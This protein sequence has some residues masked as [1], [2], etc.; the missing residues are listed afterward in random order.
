MDFVTITDFPDYEISET[1]IVRKIENKEII[2]LSTGNKYIKVAL[3]RGKN[4]FWMYLHRLLAIQFIQ[5]PENYEY[6]NHKNG[7]KKD[8]SLSNLEWCNAKQNTKHAFET[9]LRTYIP[10]F[11]GENHGRAKL[12]NVQVNYIKFLFSIGFTNKQ[13]LERFDFISKNTI[14]GIRTGKLWKHINI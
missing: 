14:S 10:S 1:G 4:R 3:Y 13:V 12:N 2:K 5:N 9:G 8:N 6:V 11:K 7:I